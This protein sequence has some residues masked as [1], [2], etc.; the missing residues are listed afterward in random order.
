[1]TAIVIPDLDEEMVGQLRQ[2]AS[3]H[4]RSVEAEAKAILR[5]VLQPSAAEVWNEL[6]AFRDKL[7]ASGRSFSDSAELLRTDRER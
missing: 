6:S 2:R 4:G 3:A 7:S 5:E 1:M